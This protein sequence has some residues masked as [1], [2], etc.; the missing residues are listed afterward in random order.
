MDAGTDVDMVEGLSDEDEVRSSLE[1]HATRLVVHAR[2]SHGAS[3]P[4]RTR[5]RPI[6]HSHTSSP[7][8]PPRVNMLSLSV[9]R[10]E[11]HI[12]DFGPATTDTL[13]LSA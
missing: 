1:V 7:R 3:H 11:E 10:C 9:L 5:E 4:I 6:V 2:R 12:M 8:Q 13:M